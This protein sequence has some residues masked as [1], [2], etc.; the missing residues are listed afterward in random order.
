[1]I[2]LK[3]ES[4]KAVNGAAVDF[5]AYY[6]ENPPPGEKK[7][8]VHGESDSDGFIH[9]VIPNGA[10]RVFSDP[11]ANENLI[12]GELGIVTVLDGVIS[13][14]GF[15]LD[16]GIT[17]IVFRTANI[18]F[19]LTFPDSTT[20]FG[21]GYLS[22]ETANSNWESTGEY[23]QANA[24]FPGTE[25]YAR[26]SLAD[27]LYLVTVNV[28]TGEPRNEG[29]ADRTYQL[30]FLNGDAVIT[31]NGSTVTKS[32][33]GH[34]PLT[35]SASNLDV[36]VKDLAGDPLTEGQIDICNDKEVNCRGYGLPSN[37]R[38][39]TSLANGDWILTLRPGSNIIGMVSKTYT[40]SVVAGVATVTSNGSPVSKDG[41]NR[42]VLTG[43]APNVSG[44][45]SLDSGSL[46]F[47]DNQGIS[48]N[49]QKFVN[50]RWEWQRGGNWLRSAN[51]GMN[52]TGAGHYRLVANPSN[53]TDL[54]QSYS[55]DFWVD[56]DKKVSSTETG[57]YQ[58]VLTNLY[59]RLK[60]PNLKLRVVNPLDENSLLPG[61]WVT[62]E[63]VIG[64]DRTWITNADIQNSNPGLTGA[65]LSE[66]GQYILTV[67]PPQGSNAIVGLAARQ[68]QLTVAAGNSMTVTLG[69]QNIPLTD[70][71]FVLSP[72]TANITARVVKSDGSPFGNTNNTWASANLQKFNANQNN[73][74]WSS[75]WANAD[76]DGY[77]S[78]RVNEVGKYRLRIEPS[79]DS[80]ATVTYSEEFTIGDGQ[81]DA[82]KKDFGSITLAGP[83]LRISVANASAPNVALDYA[84]IEI[85]KDGNW[86]DWANTQRSGVA[87]ISLRAEGIYEFITNPPDDL[88]GTS[89]RKSYKVNA[90]KNEAGAI[91]ATVTP[92]SGVSVL[93]G[94]TTLLLGQPTLSG[95][96]LAPSPLTDVQAYSQVYAYNITTGQE[97]WDYSTQTN[98]NGAWAMTL[99]AG[100][101]KIY[102]RT[103]WGTSSYGGS[104]GVGD[105]VVNASGEA[106]SVPSPLSATAFTIRLKSSTWSGLVKSPGG[107]T[108]VPNARVC[109]RLENVFTCVNADNNGAWALSAPT[110]FTNFTGKN[111]YLEINDD[112][113]RQYPQ[114]RFDTQDDVFAAIGNSGTGINLTFDDANTQITVT[115]GGQPVANVW[116]AAERDGVGWLGGGTTN[117]NGIAKLNIANPTQAFGVRVELKGNPTIS[118]AYATTMKTFSATDIT[119]GRVASVFSATVALAEPNFKVVLREPTSDGSVGNAIPYSWI[120]LYSDTT[121]MWIGGAGTDANGFASFKLDVP[122]SG[123]NNFTAAV[124][125]AWNALTNFSRQSY[126]ITVS[127][128]VITVVNKTSTNSVT[129]QNVSGRV[130][131]PL[132][133]GTPSVTGVV[134]DPSG[135]TLQNSWV[136]PIDPIT[137][138]YYWQQGSNSRSDGS[139]GLNLING[140]YKIE[141]NV[142]W[143][144]S[145]LAKSAQCSVTVAAG[146]V[147]TGGSCVQ[148]GATKTV[149]LA[150]RAPN[151]TLTLKMGG[152][153]VPNANVGIGSGKWY[154]NAQ[155]NS[156]GKISLFVDADAIR[157][158]NGYTT[159]QPLNIWVDPPYGGTIEMARWDC[160]SRDQKPICSGLVDVPATGD[161]PT[162]ALG[163]ITGVSPNTRIHIVAPG[164]S[165]DM[166]N[167]WVSI[168]AFDAAHPEYGK[169]WLGGG[170][171]NSY[172]YVS[173]NLDTS[174]VESDW[175]FAV[176]I[177][178][179][180]NQRQSYATN[181]DT[182]SGNGYSWYEITHLSDKSPSTP[183]LTITVNTSN[184][185][186]NKFGWIGVEEVNGANVY[187][188]WVGGYGLNE[189][190]ISS[191]FFP[192]SKRYR[193]TAYPGPGK[194]GARTTCIVSTNA[195]A[196]VSVVSGGCDAGTFTTGAVTIA[197]DGGNVV[198]L[199]STTTRDAG[200]N[201]VVTALA[202][203]IVYANNPNAVDEST[204][205]ITSTGS[206]GRY[207]LQLDPG[208]TWNIKVFP[209]GSGSE[210]L[211]I[212]TSTGITPPSTGSLSVNFAIAA[213]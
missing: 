153:P 151:V 185:I 87:G 6:T 205:V 52:I 84:G 42:F 139:I 175:K 35:P 201:S 202:G 127:P 50:N 155:S 24:D 177:N 48:L 138:E 206:D 195:S 46:T 57:S 122:Q 64:K 166:P 165:D 132:T 21:S 198:G 41:D 70:N 27:G 123:L 149:R 168:F 43:T 97:M 105:V 72:A 130:V 67:N 65:N 119:N 1:V 54:V 208:K 61:G 80:N 4:G 134:V 44:T 5:V 146:K 190:A 32:A 194:S 172:G 107:T 192:A 143:G 197:L 88:Q 26:T 30:T 86:I 20:V 128:T 36:A 173:T 196:V 181:M 182:N 110:G 11:F 180:W 9:L 19:D 83:S 77:I 140:S 158:T 53:F 2:Q 82:F 59:L 136:V 106:T 150:L 142:P 145:E 167:S 79:G 89:S 95:T 148:D 113:G 23:A 129:T 75:E 94:V 137:N 25:G 135:N 13:G 160:R 157:T 133:L 163:N 169:R 186:A 34:Y 108:V 154:T 55:A 91:V 176:E 100:T 51:F 37:G 60:S 174:T 16:N 45:F 144:T 124:N 58:N 207:G 17:T 114:K 102:A 187:Q 109:L 76:Q 189:N 62:I 10:Y 56:A 141:A 68:Y 28:F 99:P 49:V 85:R 183:N 210:R 66:E 111:P 191:V 39:S 14:S 184:A 74:D 40:V 156:E 209:T 199:V 12:Q 117:S 33:N 204:A 22:I 29:L 161:Y 63:K 126:A 112:F 121:G 120:E 104:D 71:R 131:Y 78:M 179:P 93:N 98:A 73:W 116:V 31:Y 178:A 18:K 125:P 92:G 171:S 38:I 15:H 152:Q 103:P 8:S 164:T 7:M 69:S 3:D 162:I 188:N 115:A 90:V 213:A 159:A 193:I 101:Y 47:A 147:S 211:G 81:L 200:G 203:A 170:N 118:S 96:V 212:G